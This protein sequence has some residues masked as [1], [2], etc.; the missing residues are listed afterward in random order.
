MSRK[1]IVAMPLIMMASC[2][3]SPITMGKT[4]VAPN[5]ATTCCAPRPIVRG[6]ESLSSGRTTAPGGGVCPPWTTFQLK[7]AM[8]D[9]ALPVTGCQRWDAPRMMLPARD[10]MG[11]V[12]PT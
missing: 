11:K 2:G 8:T 10:L 4:N 7:R 9:A 1:Q 12:L 5:I 3:L 6:Q